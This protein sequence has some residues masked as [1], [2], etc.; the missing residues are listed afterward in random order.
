ML[1][2]QT[3][4]KF[5]KIIRNNISI[6][7]HGTRIMPLFTFNKPYYIDDPYNPK[8][9]KLIKNEPLN[10]IVETI[11][12]LQIDGT[13]IR[14]IKGTMDTYP[15]LITRQI[16][17]NDGKNPYTRISMLYEKNG[18]IHLWQPLTEEILDCYDQLHKK[19]DQIVFLSGLLEAKKGQPYNIIDRYEKLGLSDTPSETLTRTCYGDSIHETILHEITKQIFIYDSMKYNESHQEGNRMMYDSIINY[20]ER[21]YTMQKI[22]TDSNMKRN[23]HPKFD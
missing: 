18:D 6:V 1:C 2:G 19:R 16:G 11:L 4:D 10:E 7:F 13:Y 3:I 22:F 9:P 12:Y 8:I 14:E 5:P 20:I 15:C 23:V 17:S 21:G